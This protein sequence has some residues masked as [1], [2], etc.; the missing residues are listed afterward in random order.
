MIGKRSLIV[1]S[2]MLILLTFCFNAQAQSSND[3]PEQPCP[4]CGT[5]NRRDAKFCKNCGIKLS[6]QP[7]SNMTTQSSV[8]YQGRSL[9]LPE[10]AAG[11]LE[12]GVTMNLD[13]LSREELIHLVRI[14]E[15]NQRDQGTGIDLPEGSIAYMTEDE[16][17]SLV[18]E[19]VGSPKQTKVQTPRQEGPVGVVLKL[20]GGV[21]VFLVIIAVIAI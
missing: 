19:I 1:L 5:M 9:I 18:T 14:M 8:P 17:R 10:T 2:I 6:A 12:P 7:E 15:K 4:A 13:S 16:L 3:Q 11:R 20:I 21:T